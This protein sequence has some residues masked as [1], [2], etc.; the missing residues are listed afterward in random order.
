MLPVIGDA[1][2]SA[3]ERVNIYAN[4]YFYRIRDSLKEDFP[5]LVQIIGEDRFHNC[6]TDY[7]LKYPSRHWS[8]RYAGDR[9]PE[10][11]KTHA[12]KKRWPFLVDLARCEWA[13][14]TAFDAADDRPMTM[15]DV[16]S[17]TPT[18]W[19]KLPLRCVASCALLQCRFDVA[20]IHE[21][22]LA[23]K[24][25]GVIAAKATRLLVWRKGLNVMFRAAD[26][27]EWALLERMQRRTS[28]A[29]LCTLAAKR[30]GAKHA[31]SHVAALFQ[32]WLAD[33]LLSVP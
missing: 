15:T 11:L 22:A 26:L 4:M 13:L 31:A 27:R 9:L 17:L 10:F 3:A 32:R 2:L 29:S 5:A 7:L 6:I 20:A 14:I 19:G 18:A 23:G 21:R 25:L 16:A 30:V 28:F 24:K 1:R 12:L 33:E 8:L